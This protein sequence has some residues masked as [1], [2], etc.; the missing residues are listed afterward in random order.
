MGFKDLVLERKY[1]S[2]GENSISK[3]VNLLLKDSVYF[4]RSV[5]FFSSSAF[6]FINEGLSYLI[7]KKGKILLITSPRLSEEDIKA[8]SIGIVNKK[9][10]IYDNFLYDF[11]ESLK[12][13]NDENLKLVSKLIAYN[14]LEIRIVNKP[15]FGMYHDKVAI[16]CDSD[17]NKVVITGSNNETKS[18]YSL[19][20]ETARLY[21]SW[22]HLDDVIDEENQFDNIWNGNDEFL[23][24][25]DFDEAYKNKLIQIIEKEKDNRSQVGKEKYILRKYQEDAI[26]SWKDNNY[27]GFFV[28]ATGTGKTVTAIY[29]LKELLKLENVLTVIA[30][31]YKHLV[32]QWYEDVI[33]IL[34]DATIIRVSSEFIDWDTKIESAIRLNKFSEDK[35]III[36]STIT[37]FYS[38]RFNHAI[39]KN[40]LKKML[41][42][43]EAHNFLNK[44]YDNKFNINYDYKLGLSAT[45]V[46]GFDNVKTDDLCGFFGGVVYNLPIEKAIGKFLVNYEYIPL[47]VYATDEDERKFALARK[48]MNACRDPKTGIIK[49]KTAYAKAYR[50]KLRTISMAENKLNSLENFIDNIDSPDHFIIYCSDG[51]LGDKR[52]LETV[53]DLLNDK[54]FLPSQFTCEENMQQRISLIENFNKGY[55]STLVAIRCLDEGINI[56]SIETAL[57]LSSNDNYREFVQRRGRILRKYKNKENAK[58]IDVIVLPSQSCVDIAKI[59]FRRFYEYAKL[60]LNKDV[61][62]KDLDDLLNEYNLDIESIQFDYDWLNIEGDDLDE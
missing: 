14:I 42:V 45:P 20:Y 41:L 13:L 53:V 18:G 23:D 26:N 60:A 33:D 50:A 39:R 56:P 11:E 3:V 36:I 38:E 47:F 31:P 57:I 24:T 12:E 44:I 9:E 8:I 6:E 4:K 59:E 52:H 58:I 17:N 16:F 46:F 34:P 27:K 10:H 55:I 19:N 2:V 62:L 40:K 1:Q 48:K 43:D 37:S 7:G 32:S 28:M 54:G 49:D 5:G 35:N 25:Y 29:A 21:K 30:V 51:L 61:L 15:D 22:I